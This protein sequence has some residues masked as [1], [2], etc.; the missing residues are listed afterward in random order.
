MLAH[1]LSSNDNATP[2]N[3]T[4]SYSNTLT[5]LPHHISFIPSP[6]CKPK[7]PNNTLG[8]VIGEGYSKAKS[9]EEAQDSILQESNTL[10]TDDYG[11]VRVRVNAF[12]SQEYI[13][14]KILGE[15]DSNADDRERSSKASDKVDGSNNINDRERRDS[16]NRDSNILDRDSHFN[17]DSNH[18]SYLRDS[19]LS[20][21]SN[22]DSK[23]SLH[24]SSSPLSR[25]NTD[26]INNTTNPSSPYSSSHPHISYTPFLRVASPIASNHSGLFAIP[27]VGD[28]VII[29]Y[30]ENDIDKPYIS[31]SLYNVSN[32]SINDLPFNDNQTSLS[33]KTI[34]RDENGINEL[35]LSNIKD[36][37]QIYLHAQ[38][39]YDE[40]IEHNFTQR[41]KHNKDSQVKGNYTESI[42]KYHKQEILGMKDVRVGAEYLT[43]VALSKDTI[44]GGS[45]TLNIGIDNKLRVAKNSSEYVGGDKN[46]EVG[47]KV[48]ERISG[49][50]NIYIRNNKEE[51][52]EGAYDLQTIKEY[53][54]ASESQINIISQD[55]ILLS[56]AKSSAFETE[57]N[58]I[59]MADNIAMNAQTDIEMRANNQVSFTIGD[60]T[61]TAKGD[62]VIIKAGGVEV[63]IDSKG[64][65]V[66]GGEVKSE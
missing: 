15:N 24:T 8:I 40:I 7:A 9:I 44:V 26:S 4:F 10:Y 22:R 50:K 61:I 17:Q 23:E 64:L 20:D 35:T 27:R 65:V 18:S 53:N 66:K 37:E 1:T 57:K 25:G 41:I 36:K 47:G 29:S 55:N 46:V 45:H 13:D 31:S 51:T 33:S 6:K 59:N 49:I 38:R 14:R 62:S 19:H 32:P 3:P 43:N 60:T 12:V 56:S 54:L 42:N 21:S 63:V 58:H 16:S 11:R 52:I 2:T 5:L 48:E 28:E 34:G 39:D 30:L